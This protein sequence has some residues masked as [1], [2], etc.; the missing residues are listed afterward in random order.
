MAQPFCIIQQI[1]FLMAKKD[2]LCGVRPTLPLGSYG[3]SKAAGE[4][5]IEAVFQRKTLAGYA[6]LRA[7][8]VYGDGSNFIRTILRLAKERDQ[9]RVIH[10]QYGVPTS[11]DWLA[12]V[13]CDLIFDQNMRFKQFPSGIYHAV[14]NGET[15][16]YGLA[17][18]ATEV[19]RDH[20]I[21]LS[22]SLNPLLP[23]WPLKILCLPLDPK[24]LV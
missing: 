17:K 4:A 21:A 20:G 5:A 14:P 16:W 24:I 8:W 2:A 23:F 10:D 12:Q 22:L 6:I 19:A 11:A 3:E 18:L 9:L 1:M 7:S 15:T 13:S